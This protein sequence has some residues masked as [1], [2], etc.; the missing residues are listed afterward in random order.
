MVGRL[1]T[2][3]YTGAAARAAHATPLPMLGVEGFSMVPWPK[4]V[5]DS[6]DN[7]F[8]NNLGSFYS[9]LILTFILVFILIIMP[10]CDIA[11][12]TAATG[13][14]NLRGSK[15]KWKCYGSV[16]LTKI[17]RMRKKKGWVVDRRLNVVPSAKRVPVP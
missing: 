6:R 11:Q 3:G 12:R 1:Y 13:L 16:I 17:P 7:S 14:R 9:P 5:S 2:W 4:M 15:P 8:R 10:Y